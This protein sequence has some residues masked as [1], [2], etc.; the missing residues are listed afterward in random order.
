MEYISATRQE[1]EEELERKSASITGSISRIK[2]EFSLP[3][4]PLKTA[5]KNHPMEVI[6]GTVVAGVSLGWVLAGKKKKKKMKGANQPS[7]TTAD[8]A[9]SEFLH[10][11]RVGRASGLNEEEAVSRA[12]A[13]SSSLSDRPLRQ[14]RR[15]LTSRI[16]DYAVDMAE[17]MIKTAMRIA[18]REAAGWIAESVRTERAKKT[19]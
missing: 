9:A 11:V 1:L 5:Y 6:I 17:A 14:S 10:L 16:T 2:K 7:T 18:A 3:T 19:Q 12:L 8:L 15:S 13:A 4:E